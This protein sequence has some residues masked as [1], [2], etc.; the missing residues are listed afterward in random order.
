MAANGDSLP[1]GGGLVVGGLFGLFRAHLGVGSSRGWGWDRWQM[2]ARFR[3]GADRRGRLD[4]DH[5]DVLVGL[6]LKLDRMAD[7]R[8]RT[9]AIL[10]G[11]RR[12][13]RG[14]QRWGLQWYDVVVGS[15]GWR[16]ATEFTTL[17][18]HLFNGLELF[19]FAVCWFRGSWI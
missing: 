3:T 19:I 17:R 15:G 11:G 1:P 10:S 13:K 7:G 16:V 6:L 4:G 8:R 14:L 5:E 12:G 2:E 18:L 9:T